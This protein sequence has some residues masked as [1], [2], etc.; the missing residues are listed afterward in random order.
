MIAPRYLLQFGK[1]KGRHIE[2]IFDENP[3]YC[4]W[5]YSQPILKA[6]PFIYDFLEN[7]IVD[8]NAYYLNFGKHKGKT[9]DW[10]KEN[11][12]NYLY[13]LKGNNY[14]QQNCPELLIKLEK[15]IN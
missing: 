1:Y 12:K 6:N 5:L 7:K 10:I 9:L 8:K 13:W 15:I 11:D 2:E 3:N 4:K 14:V